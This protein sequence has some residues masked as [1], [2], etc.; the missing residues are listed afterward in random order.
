M[1]AHIADGW[2]VVPYDGDE[3]ATVEISVE[4]D[5]C[6]R[7]LRVT[8]EW[9]PAYLD[10]TDGKRVAKIRPPAGLTSVTVS[11]RVNGS[12]ST[13]GWLKL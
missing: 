11:L 9:L 3:R 13:V 7:D 8:Q 5:V 4:P 12:T 6:S 1:S 10:Y 2:L